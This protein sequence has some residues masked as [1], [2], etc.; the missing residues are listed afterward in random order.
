VTQLTD[1]IFCTYF[2][3]LAPFPL[4]NDA[5]PVAQLSYDQLQDFVL[6]IDVRDFLDPLSHVLNCLHTLAHA[7]RILS[8]LD[9]C[10]HVNDH[11][12][13]MITKFCVRMCT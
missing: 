10:M 7:Y 2:S 3:S 6:S 5:N 1:T 8:L 13:R 12:R 9:Q 11:T 4:N